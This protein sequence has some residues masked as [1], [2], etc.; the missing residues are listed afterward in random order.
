MSVPSVEDHGHH[1]Q[2]ELGQRAHLGRVRQAGAGLLDG[3]GDQ[4]LDLE[5]RQGRRLGDDGHLDVGDVGEGVDR[6]LAE[7]RPTRRRRGA[8]RAASPPAGGAARARPAVPSQLSSPSPLTRADLRKNTPWTAT[9]SPAATPSSDLVPAAVEQRRGR[10]VGPRR[11][12]ADVR[13]KTTSAAPT[14]IT[15]DSGHRGS[16]TRLPVGHR[17]LDEHAGEELGEAVER[18]AP[19]PARCGWWGRPRA[20]G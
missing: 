19:A 15:A 8:R 16:L 4:L 20:L 1:R 13:T 18:P 5:R 10:P 2:A 11:S 3:V 9:S 6:Q 17:A 12:V 7:G 14:R